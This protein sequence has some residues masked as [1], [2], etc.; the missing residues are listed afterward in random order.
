MPERGWKLK[1]E[2]KWDGKD[3]SFQFRITGMSESDN[4]KCPMTRR[5]V[6]G[7]STF[8]EGTP[9]SVKSDMQRIV[10]LS[11]IEVEIIAG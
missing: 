1:P 5:S 9:I 10:V 8:L 3:K 2:C 11:V 6:S 7:Y 4:T